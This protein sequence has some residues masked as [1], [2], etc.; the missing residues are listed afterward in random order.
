MVMDITYVAAEGLGED[1][2]DGEIDEPEPAVDGEG[3]EEEE[4]TGPISRALALQLQTEA[5]VLGAG[6]DSEGGSEGG[7]A[8]LSRKGGRWAWCIGLVGKPSAGKSTF[9]N[10]VAGSELAKVRSGHFFLIILILKA[11]IC[12]D[13][14]GTNATKTQ[15]SQPFCWQVGATPFTTIDPN[16]HQATINVEGP[17][18]EPGGCVVRCPVPVTVKDVAGLV[19]GAC[20]GLGKGNRFLNDLCDADVLVHII[21][22]SG[23][24]DERGNANE[25]GGHE[26]VH[27]VAWIHNEL[28]R[29]IFDNLLEKK[30]G[31]KR[32]PE[33]LYD[34]FTGYQAQHWLTH[35]ALRLAGV[36]DGENLSETAVK[37]MTDETL[38]SVI[39]HFLAVRF[40]TVLAANKCDDGDAA[41]NVKL[42]KECLGAIGSLG[43]AGVAAV[44]PLSARLECQLQKMAKE[45]KIDYTPLHTFSDSDGAAAQQ[46]AGQQAAEPALVSV[47]AEKSE[48]KAA[49]AATIDSAAAFGLMGGSQVG[50]GED[51]DDDGEAGVCVGSTGVR[52]VLAC[53]MRLR[54]PVLVWPVVDLAT[55][56]SYPILPEEPRSNVM[57]C[58]DVV[59]LK[60]G[61][62]VLSL[63]EILLHPPWSLLGTYACTQRAS[64]ECFHRPGLKL[65]ESH[66][67]VRH[68]QVENTFAVRVGHEV[69]AQRDS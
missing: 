43:E 6:A 26:I 28:Q 19:P 52:E 30:A 44:V 61:T 35:E 67:F 55:G 13:R 15:K 58:R 22:A 68:P 50:K 39:D 38:S 29:W 34:M 60:P 64:H 18:L 7:I 2:E 12:Q 63:F 47:V 46:P 66:T 56:A 53:A 27:D 4:E 24:T 42:L 33:H 54:P 62:T 36:V 65:T 17:V 51:D 21:D 41:A 5:A 32:K 31:W 48:L 1:E 23:K 57:V 25:V 10:A 11:I 8:P 16:V 49:E 40:P 69:A 9:F 3:E 37:E 59:V 45:K 20:D 14:L